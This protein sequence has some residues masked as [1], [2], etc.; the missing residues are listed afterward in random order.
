MR[1]FTANPTV[2]AQCDRCGFI[3]RH[4]ELRKEWTGLRVCSD[5]YDPKTKQEFPDPIDSDSSTVRDPRP[6]NDKI[7]NTGEAQ[8][9]LDF[10]PR[11]WR[12][13]AGICRTGQVQVV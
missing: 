2:K 4:R 7:V 1:T 12:V 9:A 11:S 13:G 10:I 6:R 8:T 5:C 3:Y